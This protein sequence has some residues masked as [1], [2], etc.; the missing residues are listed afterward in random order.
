MNKPEII[1]IA[2]LAEFNRAIAK[3]GKLPRS[4]LEDSQ[5]FLLLTLNHTVLMDRKNWEN[6]LQKRPL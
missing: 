4:S 6:D 2:T 1:I 3:N 5:R